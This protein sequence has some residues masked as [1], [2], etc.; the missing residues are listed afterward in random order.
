MTHAR[1][2]TATSGMVAA[3]LM[4]PEFM[5]TRLAATA[6]HPAGVIRHHHAPYMR[7]LCDMGESPGRR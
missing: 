2:D 1:T 3:T 4:A 7:E 6:H 5:L